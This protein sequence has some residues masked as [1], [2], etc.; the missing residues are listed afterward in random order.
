VILGAMDPDA[1]DREFLYQHD[2]GLARM[3]R[4]VEQ[5]AEAQ[6][7]DLAANGGHAAA[8]AAE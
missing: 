2:T 4:A 6:L 5:E 1:R 3:R 8:A 7:S